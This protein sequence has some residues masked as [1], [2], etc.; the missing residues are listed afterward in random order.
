LGFFTRMSTLLLALSMSGALYFSLR[1]GEASWHLAGLYCLS[2][3]ALGLT[4]PGKFSIDYV[5]RMSFTGRRENARLED[6]SEA[7]NAGEKK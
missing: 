2:F 6:E 4:G 5:V 7:L 3:L 1:M